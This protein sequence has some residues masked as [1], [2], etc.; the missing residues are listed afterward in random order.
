MSGG[1]IVLQAIE[2]VVVGAL[3][4]VAGHVFPGLPLAVGIAIL[5]VSVAA[6][7]TL[8]FGLR[9]RFSVRERGRPTPGPCSPL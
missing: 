9:R 3:L 2:L 5:I 6:V 7:T 8:T 1:W 4:R